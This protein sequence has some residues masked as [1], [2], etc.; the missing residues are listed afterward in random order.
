MLDPTPLHPR[1]LG[2]NSPTMLIIAALAT[3]GML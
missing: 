1:A 3:I 2:Y